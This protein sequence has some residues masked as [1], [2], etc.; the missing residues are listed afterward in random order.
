MCHLPRHLSR[1]SSGSR[2]SFRQ[3]TLVPGLLVVAWLL[4]FGT[5]RPVIAQEANGQDA[6]LASNPIV[7]FS[8]YYGGTGGECSFNECGIAVDQD[9]YIYIAGTT[10]SED[11]PLV[12]EYAGDSAPGGAEV[13]LV[14][15][16]PNGESVV[17]STL[18]G[19]GRAFAVTADDEGNAYVTGFT[20]SGN[21]PTTENALQ[22]CDGIAGD[23][24]NVFVVKMGPTGGEDQLLY[25]TCLGGSDVDTGYAIE[26]DGAGNIYV[27]GE[28]VSG[29]FPTVNAAQEIYGGDTDVFAFK[30]AADGSALLY[31]TYLGG[32]ARESSRGLAVDGA[33]DAYLSGRTSST[34]FPTTPGALQGELVVDF[35]SDGFVTKLTPTGSFAYSTYLGF[36][37]LPELA[38]DIA[39]DDSGNGYVL[40]SGSAQPTTV[41][42]LNAS[43][44]AILYRT[45]INH[46]LGPDVNEGS[47]VVDG[48]GN[49][50]AAGYLLNNAS[51]IPIA[52]LNEDGRLV[53]EDAVGSSGS[54]YGTGVALYE[55]SEGSVDAYIVGYTSADDFPTVNPIQATRNSELNDLVIFNLTGL[56]EVWNVEAIFLP[57]VT[58]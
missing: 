46:V 56:E 30:L 14:K 53:F 44:S 18:I 43:G 12:N 58:R 17:Y 19:S 41:V 21:F 33:G 13:F 50:L 51:N 57:L 11:F 4:L 15:L 27:T 9:G 25:G 1:F 26:L 20:A 36:V 24:G 29:D 39:I 45:E 8:S 28:T 40:M 48:V 32:A 42:K 37:D 5:A 54:D 23:V 52:A 3:V 7:A 49:V 47:L 6:V 10:N 2:A 55:D 38:N 31:S 16:T 22:S 34:N 35:Y